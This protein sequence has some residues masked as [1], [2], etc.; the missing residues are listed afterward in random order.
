MELLPISIMAFDENISPEYV[1]DPIGN[2]IEQEGMD[3]FYEKLRALC[4]EQQMTVLKYYFEGYTYS[5]IASIMNLP[6]KKIDNVLLAVKKKIKQ[7]K[8]LFV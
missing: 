8:E 6:T 2:Y 4:S 5:E 7:N 1:G 3:G